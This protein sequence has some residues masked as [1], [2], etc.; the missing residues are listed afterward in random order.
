[1]NQFFETITT[2]FDSGAHADIIYLDFSKA[3][4]KVPKERLLLKLIEHSIEG[5]IHAGIRDWLTGRKQR[6]VLKGK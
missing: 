6:V 1:M 2:Y 4:D 5:K 3:F